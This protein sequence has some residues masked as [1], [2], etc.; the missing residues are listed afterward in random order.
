LQFVFGL[1]LGNKLAGPLWLFHNGR[2][3]QEMLLEVWL[4]FGCRLVLKPVLGRYF[5]SKKYDILLFYNLNSS[6]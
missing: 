5:F 4:G 3:W 1:C 6:V 2:A